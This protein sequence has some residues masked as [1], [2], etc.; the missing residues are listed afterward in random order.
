MF[1]VL[2]PYKSA[3]HNLCCL[4]RMLMEPQVSK[5]PPLELNI[6]YLWR[7]KL[8]VQRAEDYI[9]NVTWYCGKHTWPGEGGSGLFH[10]RWVF[11]V[12]CS[13]SCHPT[14]GHQPQTGRRTHVPAVFVL[15]TCAASYGVPPQCTCFPSTPI[16]SYRMLLM[17]QCSNVDN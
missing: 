14:G 1:S 11:A 17:L 3:T 9:N 6:Q 12:S 2:H 7:A 16:F 15:A 5:K 10:D 13:V 4:K 8:S